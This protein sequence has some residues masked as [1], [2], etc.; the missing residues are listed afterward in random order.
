M[1]NQRTEAILNI[2]SCNVIGKVRNVTPNNKVKMFIRT[3][4]NKDVN[5][6]VD[7][8]LNPTLY[9]QILLYFNSWV[10]LE[11]VEGVLNRFIRE[12]D[13]EHAIIANTSDIIK[14]I[15]GNVGIMKKKDFYESYCNIINCSKRTAQ[16]HLTKA[17]ENRIIKEE[18]LHEISIDVKEDDNQNQEAEVEVDITTLLSES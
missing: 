8:R 3:I 14:L 4:N 5:K 10:E 1:T 15:V 11:L 18:S 7:L 16:R 17:I 9:N 6:T 13:D 2:Q 12:V